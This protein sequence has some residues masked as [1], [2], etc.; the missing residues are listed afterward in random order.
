MLSSVMYLY[1]TLSHNFSLEFLADLYLMGWF[2]IK[3]R[4]V[5]CCGPWDAFSWGSHSDGT[6][7]RRRPVGAGPRSPKAPEPKGVTGAG[8]G[9]PRGGVPFG[10]LPVVVQ[11]RGQGGLAPGPAAAGVPP[12]PFDPRSGRP[13]RV[14]PRPYWLGE[15]GLRQSS[16][17][18]PGSIP[19]RVGLSRW[20]RRCA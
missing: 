3:S 8:P 14:L 19:P 11:G 5:S 6:L 15:P 13:P 17:R 18:A 10:L 20:R 7:C 9:P 2:L 12:L 4:L 1:I 16:G